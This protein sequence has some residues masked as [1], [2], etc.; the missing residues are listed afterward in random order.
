MRKDKKFCKKRC[1]R[2]K[3]LPLCADLY[4]P[5]YKEPQRLRERARALVL[6]GCERATPALLLRSTEPTIDADD[7]QA[8]MP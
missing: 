5:S 3:I 2:K 6:G 1:K 4:R 7:V 8:V